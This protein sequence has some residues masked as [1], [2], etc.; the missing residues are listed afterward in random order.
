[1][2]A[3]SRAII[4]DGKQVWLVDWE[5]AA[6]GVAPGEAYLGVVLPPS[7]PDAQAL[8]LHEGAEA[9]AAAGI[10]RVGVFRSDRF[11]AEEG[12]R[13]DDRPRRRHSARRGARDRHLELTKG[14]LRKKL[15]VVL[16]KG[17]AAP[18]ALAEHLPQHLE[19]MIGLE[20]KG[21]LFASGPLS[22]AS[23]YLIYQDGGIGDSQPSTS[24]P[25][26]LTIATVPA[27]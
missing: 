9:L 4:A 16:S 1:M 25:T 19:Y 13:R 11:V 3:S 14:M 6:M 26:A 8:A 24:V 5:G 27:R 18:E 7:L 21:V 2:R 12:E 23:T 20:K 22:A 17:G 10:D 15:Y